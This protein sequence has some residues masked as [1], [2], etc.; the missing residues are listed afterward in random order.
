MSKRTKPAKKSPAKAKRKARPTRRATRVKPAAR[1][2]A[3]SSR[4]PRGKAAARKRG[5]KIVPRSTAR[6]KKR[7]PPKALSRGGPKGHAAPAARPRDK[8]KAKLATQKAPKALAKAVPPPEAKP[9][10]T[11]GK[12]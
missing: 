9:V 7:V 8:A 4:T 10:K 3:K 1:R 5:G 6:A 11:T 2:P 12:S